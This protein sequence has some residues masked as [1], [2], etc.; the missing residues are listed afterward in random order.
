MSDAPKDKKKEEPKGAEPEKEGG[1]AGKKKLPIKLIGAVAVLMIVEGAGV[2]MLV[3]MTSPKPAAAE[4]EIKEHENAAGDHMSEIALIEDKTFQNM[5][6]GRVWNWT[7]S[8]VLQAKEKNVGKIEEEMASRE[9][10]IQEGISRI[11]AKAQ[12]SHL[13]DPEL[14]VIQRQ[15]GDFLKTVFEPDV[16]GHSRIERVLIP[17]FTGK[18]SNF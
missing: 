8:I 14:R 13:Q 15:V 7:V 3:S 6:S 5:L 12:L 1:G 4:V 11:I 16:E 17:V 9:A 10:E 2:F 18:Q